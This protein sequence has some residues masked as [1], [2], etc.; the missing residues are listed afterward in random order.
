M[1]LAHMPEMERPEY[2]PL[3]MGFV[4]NHGP[5]NIS[6]KKARETYGKL[7]SEYQLLSRKNTRKLKKALNLDIGKIISGRLKSGQEDLKKTVIDFFAGWHRNYEDEF[8]VHIAPLLN[9]NDPAKVRAALK[10]NQD[11]L[12]R[13]L[14]LDVR[15]E[16]VRRNLIRKDVLNSI[17]QDRLAA[18]VVHMLEKKARQMLPADCAQ[19][20]REALSK[21]HAHSIL[22]TLKHSIG[23]PEAGFPREMIDVYADDIAAALYPIAR[24][25]DL[26]GVGGL[27]LVQGRGVEFQ[28]AARNR[29]YLTLGK[30]T[31]DCTADKPL[32]QADPGVEN[33]Y[34][35]IFPWILDRNYQILKVFFNGEFIMKVHILPLFRLSPQGGRIILAVDAIETRRT[36][37]DDLE[38][39]YRQ[40]LMVRREHIFQTVLAQIRSIAGSMGIYDIYAEKFSNTPW[41]RL[42]LSRLPEIL[43][44]VHQLIKLDELE[45]V[46]ELAGLLSRKEG[47]NEV[48]HVFMELQMKN[49]SLLPGVTKKMEGIKSFAVVHGNPADGIPMKQV[50]GI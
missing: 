36:F 29:S 4:K 34:W 24:K 39:H 37:R 20:L 2:N 19:T 35:T 47:Q 25:S 13:M 45:D 28:F 38:D 7:P 44:N 26:G 21:V 12:M 31:G 15:D 10:E 46:Y 8:G 43:I 22:Q 16:V 6:L 40:D 14:H 3:I 41:V 33:I 18:T 17:P 11:F 5:V 32:F 42:E 30:D 50:V 1:D 48:K 27:Q 9:L 49:T 23:L